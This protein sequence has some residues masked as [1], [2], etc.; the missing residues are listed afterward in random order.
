[1]I[2][3]QRQKTEQ[4]Q[5]GQT[6]TKL[7][8]SEP[9]GTSLLKP[10]TEHSWH[11]TTV[12]LQQRAGSPR[13]DSRSSY[14]S[15]EHTQPHEHS[16]KV[17]WK[18]LSRVQLSA[19][20]WTVPARVL[21]RVGFSRRGYWSGLRFPSPGDLPDP[22]I[23]PKSPAWQADSLPTKLQG[24]PLRLALTTTGTLGKGE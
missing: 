20:P 21:C 17:K 22:G 14:F 15:S 4:N 8:S 3:K 24:K 7:V 9:L 6:A 10:R 13:K 23:E 5:M 1:M 12:P 2:S 18:S 19:T 11:A 16:S